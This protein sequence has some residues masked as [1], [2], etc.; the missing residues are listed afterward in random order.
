MSSR[1]DPYCKANK[2]NIGKGTRRSSRRISD[3]RES[4]TVAVLMNNYLGVDAGDLNSSDST[5]L[6]LSY[7]L[8]RPCC[9][10]GAHHTM[11]SLPA[12]RSTNVGRGDRPLSIGWVP[13]LLIAARAMK[14]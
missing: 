11:Y 9:H 2:I 12:R 4:A 6:Q 10:R 7:A 5:G 1:E 14:A 3:V 8:A 13:A